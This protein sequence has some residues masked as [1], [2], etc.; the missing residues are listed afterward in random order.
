MVERAFFCLTDKLE[1]LKDEPALKGC[2]KLTHWLVMFDS[3][4][5]ENNRASKET[6]R[7]SANMLI[8]LPPR[9]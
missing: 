6:G 4:S 2:D 9:G 3:E 7:F 8:K 5:E 1:E